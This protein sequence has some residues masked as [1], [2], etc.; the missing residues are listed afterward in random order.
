M[1]RTSLIWLEMDDC[2]NHY[3][4]V[5]SIKA[6]RRLR[7]SCGI[8]LQQLNLF[9]DRQNLDKA[10]YATEL[11]ARSASYARWRESLRSL[12]SPPEDGV[13]SVPYLTSRLR[14]SLP[15][16]TTYVLEA[17]TNAGHLIHHLNLTK[18]FV[19]THHVVSS[20]KRTLQPGTLFGSGAGGLG[21]GG[22]AALGVKL[23]K[24]D[25][26]ICAM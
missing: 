13:V 5:F 26:F 12:E 8:A 9:L 19:H 16:D 21:W 7:V 10:H 11:E 25:S 2:V 22:G 17:V 1:P 3:R 14:Q 23:A 24:P 15:Q 6:I 20:T 4:T 18:V